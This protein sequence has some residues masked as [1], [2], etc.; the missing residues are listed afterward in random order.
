MLQFMVYINTYVVIFKVLFCF[1]VPLAK[2]M[3]SDIQN[4]QKNA[5]YSDKTQHVNFRGNLYQATK[6]HLNNS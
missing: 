5:I 2:F 4:V 1:D 6:R 3:Y